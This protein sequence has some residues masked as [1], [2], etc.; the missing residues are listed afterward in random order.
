[1]QARATLADKQPIG[2]L[3]TPDEV[4]VAVMSCV[5]NGA[6]NG[7]AIVVDGGAVQA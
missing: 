4:A 7:Q 1:M 3:I 2:R 6:L 5:D